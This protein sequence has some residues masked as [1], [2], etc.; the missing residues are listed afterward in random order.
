MAKVSEGGRKKKHIYRV[1]SEGSTI[2]TQVEEG[3]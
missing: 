3:N 1:G 2:G